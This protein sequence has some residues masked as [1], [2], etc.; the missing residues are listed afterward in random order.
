M[1]FNEFE[2]IRLSAYELLDWE[3]GE[4]ERT[5]QQSEVA[6][7]IG[8]KILLFYVVNQYCLSFIR[9]ACQKQQ[10]T[11]LELAHKL[12]STDDLHARYVSSLH[13]SFS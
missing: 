4:L 13:E 11:P 12:V 6:G 2:N 1:I 8:G 9:T 10:Y 3:S 5:L 7:S